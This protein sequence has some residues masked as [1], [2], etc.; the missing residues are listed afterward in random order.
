[1][2]R[3]HGEGDIMAVWQFD[4]YLIPPGST[5]P[6]TSI[7]DWEPVLPAH[8]TYALQEDF[9]HYLGRP[10]LMLPDWIVFDPENG[11]R[12]DFNFVDAGD[13]IVQVRLDTRNEAPQFVVLIADL[14]KLHDC[15]FFAESGEFIQAD[16]DQLM[17]ALVRREVQLL[18]LR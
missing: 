11:N 6:D 16:R 5:A 4:L 10:W 13:A 2:R 18:G 3:T 8:I 15:V 17:D 7:P 9:V 1:M 14:A 12:I